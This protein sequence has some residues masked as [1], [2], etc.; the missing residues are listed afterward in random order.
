M[1]LLRLGGQVQLSTDANDTAPLN[2]SAGRQVSASGSLPGVLGGALIG[3]IGNGKPF[4][5]GEQTTITAPATG[6][7]YLGVNDDMLHRQQRRVR[8]D[9][10]GRHGDR[11]PQ[12]RLP[13]PTAGASGCKPLRPLLPAAHRNEL[14][15]TRPEIRPD[16]LSDY[17]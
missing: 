5:I 6:P 17:N 3:R 7:L 10:Y 13:E 15:R 1:Q 16:R 9:D 11:H 12:V 8:R 4:G 2:G 14:S